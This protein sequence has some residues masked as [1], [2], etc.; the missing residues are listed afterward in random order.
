[1]TL[2]TCAT[3]G[4][5]DAGGEVCAPTKVDTTSTGSIAPSAKGLKPAADGVP[6]PPGAEDLSTQRAQVP[7][8]IGRVAPEITG[9]MPTASLE[10]A[11]RGAEAN[12]K[13]AR[14]PARLTLNE[15]VAV[16]VLSHPAMGAQAAKIRS[17]QADISAAQAAKRP[18]LEVTAGAGAATLGG[19]TTLPNFVGKPNA[20]PAGRVDVGYTFRQ[21]VY[22]FG[23]AQA[24]VRRNASL[25]DAER[26]KL[27]DQAEDIALRTVNAY[28]NLLEQ[29]ELLRLID[30][31]V[32]AQ[33]KLGAL[34]SMN[35]KDGNGTKADVDRINA[36][37]IETEAMRAD[38]NSAYRIALDEFR[39]LTSLEPK[40]VIRP[41]SLAKVIPANALAA[42]DVAKRDNPSLLALQATGR[43]FG[44]A[45]EEIK[46]Q[47][48]PRID[49]VSDTTSHN[50]FGSKTAS[51]GTLDARVML[52]VSYKLLDGGLLRA[53]AERILANQQANE[54]K[55][56]DEAETIEL[57]LRR[58]YQSLAA[59]RLKRA[60]ALR[61]IHTAESA[62]DLYVK[63]FKEGKRTI[64]EVLDSNMVVFNMRRVSISGEFEE[65]RAMYGILRNMGLLVPTIA[66]VA[67]EPAPKSARGLKSRKVADV[68]RADMTASVVPV[69]PAAVKTSLAVKASPA[70]K[71]LV[72][73]PA[74]AKSAAVKAAVVAAAPK[75]EDAT[76][77][78]RKLDPAPSQPDFRVHRAG[79]KA[80]LQWGAQTAN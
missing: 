23:A 28:L 13:P 78:I 72:A 58:F 48:K 37:I 8:I 6:P 71:S 29:S 65:L 20:P 79:E 53:Q 62:N 52:S 1:M 11:S 55:S 41:G 12:D 9:A 80:P 40:H 74:A 66:R 76:G 7:Q 32:G 44:H 3:R 4:A 39:R 56:L 33:R 15:A 42:L 17:A 50:Y 34:V 67:P 21:L 30:A 35:Q 22:D 31:T 47:R 54:F 73:R 25:V 57:N 27:A 16:A 61:G 10:M 2:A 63:Q 43:S 49:L 70:V 5:G 45:L 75:R 18:M 26:L 59:N 14:G 38:I 60:S 68:E 19:Y 77:S 51:V 24:E 64:F 46:A 69:K 36:K